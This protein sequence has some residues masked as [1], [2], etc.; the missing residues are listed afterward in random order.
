MDL[1]AERQQRILLDKVVAGLTGQNE[2]LTKET[3]ALQKQLAEVD[4]ELKSSREQLQLLTVELAS[5]RARLVSGQW[6]EKRLE[7][8][9]RARAIRRGLTAALIVSPFQ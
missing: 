1:E 6:W 5:E 7:Q 4:D 8:N 2:L 9:G 3:E